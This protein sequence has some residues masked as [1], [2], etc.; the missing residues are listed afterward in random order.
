MRREYSVDAYTNFF[1]SRCDF[2]SSAPGTCIA[3]DPCSIIFIGVGS[4]LRLGGGVKVE[5]N[6]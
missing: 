1:C 5:A 4:S 2:T 3:R 6:V